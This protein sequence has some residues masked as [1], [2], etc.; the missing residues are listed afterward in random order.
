MSLYG[1]SLDDT[2]MTAPSRIKPKI[3]RVAIEEVQTA[4]ID[5]AAPNVQEAIARVQ[6][7]KGLLVKTSHKDRL[8]DTARIVP[9][10]SN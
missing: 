2:P 7:G 4:Y 1:I 6:K 10:P 5:I 3:Y 9:R 8:L